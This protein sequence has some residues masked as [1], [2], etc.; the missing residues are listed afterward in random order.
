MT[1]GIW[2]ICIIVG[3]GEAAILSVCTTS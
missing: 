3:R 1:D 2:T